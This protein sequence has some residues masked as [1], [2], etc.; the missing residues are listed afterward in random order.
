VRY[1]RDHIWTVHFYRPRWGVFGVW[2]LYR[3]WLSEVGA[4][5]IECFSALLSHLLE[6]WTLILFK[7]ILYLNYLGSLFRTSVSSMMRTPL[8]VW[9]TGPSGIETLTPQM[10]TQSKPK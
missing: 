8:N 4:W 6:T 5:T 3:E 9:G 7:L 1:E 2:E 10:T